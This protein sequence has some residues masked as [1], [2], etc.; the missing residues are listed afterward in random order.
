MEGGFKIN[1]HHHQD[2]AA[3]D[4][5]DASSTS[6]P[7]EDD[8]Q[9]GWEDVKPD[10]EEV[11]F[12]SLFEDKRF[13]DLTELLDYDRRMHC[14]DL[15]QILKSLDLDF[16]G[17][18]RLVNYVRSEVRDSD[19]WPDVSD[20]EL[21]EDEKYLKP[22]IEDDAL[23][24]SLEDVLVQAAGPKQ[25]GDSA[26]S[27]A[28]V[29]DLRNELEQLQTRFAAYRE[30]VQ[31][32][33]LDRVD[34]P[35][36]HSPDP[37]QPSSGAPPTRTTEE[38]AQ[39]DLEGGYFSSYSYNA[40]H[41]SMLKDSVRTDAYRDFI[42]DNK[43]LFRDKVVLDVG[44]GTG[45][46]SMFCAKAGAKKVIAVDNS[47][48]IDKA[49]QNVFENEFQDT[50][51]CVRG[52][53]ETVTL[54]VPKVD[55]IVSEWM[56]YCL[57]YES[58]LDSVIHARD[59][60]LAPDGLMIPSHASLRIAPIA[61]SELIASH[62]D[63]WK[64]IYGFKMTG[65][66]ENVYDEALIRSVYPKELAAESF[67]FLE[68]DL[69]TARLIDLTFYNTFE[70][71]WK[72]GFDYLHGFAIWFDMFFAR[73]RNES[74]LPE[75]TLDQARRKGMVAFTTGPDAVQT[76]WQQGALLLKKHDTKLEEGMKLSGSVGYQRMKDQQRSLEI[77][78]SWKAPPVPEVQRQVWTL[79]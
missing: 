67:S 9:E 6:D 45:I 25:N 78:V 26:V 32:A 3:L 13:G 65:M 74:V 33:L 61:D 10:K 38:K 15:K 53:I 21:F 18:V 68:L 63:F 66:L 27:T 62:A 79:N 70:L 8:D 49:R 77:E 29:Q 56:G 24:W 43:H 11:S 19:K 55:V 57:L 4:L 73:G 12:M 46:L 35:P 40:I 23:L 2:T 39:D 14:F 50:I 17:A 5:D 41:E 31:R 22:V 30:E 16:M 58:M 75:M 37:G 52:M 47:D 76:H 69:H 42:Y 54:P 7:Q 34:D 28:E 60:Y 51:T 1:S 72:E 48:I 44:C 71:V 20:R 36:K 64:H 59:K